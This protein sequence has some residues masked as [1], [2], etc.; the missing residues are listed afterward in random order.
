MPP[1][2]V[3]SPPSPAKQ[4]IIA[5]IRAG[6]AA[7]AQ[8]MANLRREEELVNKIGNIEKERVKI[9]RHVRARTRV[10]AGGSN[11]SRRNNAINTRLNRNMEK[12]TLKIREL[13]ANLVAVRRR[14]MGGATRMSNHNILIGVNYSGRKAEINRMQLKRLARL[15]PEGIIKRVLNRRKA[16]NLLRERLS[17]HQRPNSSVRPSNVKAGRIISI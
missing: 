17:L 9:E 13:E 6:Q 3:G 10:H 2:R 15:F 8:L 1:V 7:Y 5:N 16:R 4:K 12:K 14:L 11:A